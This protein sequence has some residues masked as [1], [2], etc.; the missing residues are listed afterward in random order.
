[1]INIYVH[2]YFKS[3]YSFHL[4]AMHLETHLN[5]NLK[6]PISCNYRCTCLCTQSRKFPSSIPS[7]FQS[8][9]KTY[10]K[11]K[12]CSYAHSAKD[13]CQGNFMLSIDCNPV[14]SLLQTRLLGTPRLAYT[15]QS[16]SNQRENGLIMKNCYKT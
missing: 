1:M 8:S 2:L 5:A 13:S 6:I 7:S 9:H 11:E 14:T 16:L 10:M 15:N 4:K 12:T 3:S